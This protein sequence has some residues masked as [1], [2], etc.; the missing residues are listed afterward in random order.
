M[1]RDPY[2]D[3]AQALVDHHG[4]YINLAHILSELE[5]IH[6][7][8]ESG[9]SSEFLEGENIIGF[10]LKQRGY[11]GTAGGNGYTRLTTQQCEE[12][13]WD[14]DCFPLTF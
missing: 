11:Q 3:I 7:T 5:P 6:S 1:L 10:F 2:E 4:D 9:P 8:E 14:R 13:G 12:Q